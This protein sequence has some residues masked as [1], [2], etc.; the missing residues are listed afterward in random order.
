MKSFDARMADRMEA[1]AQ[2]NQF[3][4]LAL[5]VYQCECQR[6][7]FAKAEE[8]RLKVVAALENYLDAFMA[9]NRELALARG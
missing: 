3:Y 1:T 8:E 7:D 4:D 5:R 9:A 2:A 6:G